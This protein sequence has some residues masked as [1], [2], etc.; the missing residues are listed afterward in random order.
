MSEENIMKI[1]TTC[2]AL[3][4]VFSYLSVQ[5]QSAKS[6]YGELGG[7]GFISAN[8]DSRFTGKNS[9]LGGRIGIG[10][11]VIDDRGFISVPAGLNF[12]LGK[13]NKNFLEL[14]LGATY[15]VFLNAVEDGGNSS[16]NGFFGHLWLG[17][18]YQPADKRLMFRVGVCPI[19]IGEFFFPYYGGLSV[20]CRL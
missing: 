11:F 1:K 14:G 3:V 20:G 13:D 15:I 18:R 8:Y 16:V 17:Y 5:A 10:V 4:L 9:G 12:L 2:I 19:L 6:I 7:P